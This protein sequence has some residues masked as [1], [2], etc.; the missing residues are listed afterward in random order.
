MKQPLLSS[1]NTRSN[2]NKGGLRSI[3]Q[4][5]MA[6][7]ALTQQ[8]LPLLPHGED[9]QV[10]SYED[11]ILCI[12]AQHH[13][14]ASRLR[15]LQQQYLEPIRALPTFAGIQ[16]IKVIVEPPPSPRIRPTGQPVALSAASR[17]VLL[18]SA[19]LFD[20]PELNQALLRIASKK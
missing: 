17:Q 18:E 19:T 1:K 20:D 13:A 5:V 3:Q 8:I 4:Q 11:G 16:T 2:Q 10:A 15:Y 9:W 14:A 7:Q 12:V 6:L